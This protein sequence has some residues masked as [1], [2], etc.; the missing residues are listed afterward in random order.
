[1]T[2][3]NIFTGTSANDG[4]GDTLRSAGTKINANFVELY[5]R[6]GGDSNTL[7]SGVTFTNDAVV[8]E[9]SSLDDFET[10]VQAIDPTADRV[11]Q[12]PDAAGIVVLDSATQTLTN[13]TLTSPIL[14]TPQI[15]DTS[16]DHQYIIAVN[17]LAADR[18]ITLPLLTTN[19]T[20]T[21]NA[22]AQTLTNKT[23]TSP[24]LNTPSIVTAI[25]DTNGA[26]VVEIG[27]TASAVN[28]IKITNAA[29]GGLP[30]IEAVGDDTNISITLSAK[31]TGGIKIGSRLIHDAETLTSSGAIS[32]AY[33]LTLIDAA[34]ATSMTLADGSTI[35]EHKYIL[36]EG[37]GTSTVTPTSFS[38]GTS[39]SI[40]TDGIAELMWSG[41]NW[42]LR[43]D[44][45]WDSS[46]TDAL[47]YVTP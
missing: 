42:H 22:A 21:F 24:T 14:T 8:Y 28:H 26:E 5:R 38:N 10:S 11:I 47:V 33:S 45:N 2:R 40:R 7:A 37:V 12:Y 43:V 19:D 4:T 31:G 16:A 13:K 6:L 1:M 46:D 41:D 9:G 29:T 3:Q 44:K 17:E 39:F 23:L 34:T 35:G 18:T 25:N 27:A 15:N 30:V 32:L 36:N 20:F